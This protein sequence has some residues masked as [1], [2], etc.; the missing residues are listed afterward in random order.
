MRECFA[1]YL[2]ASVAWRQ[3]SSS[4]MASVTVGSTP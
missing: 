2:P 4:P 1:S 3:K